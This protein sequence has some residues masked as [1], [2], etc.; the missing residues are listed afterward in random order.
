MVQRKVFEGGDN[1]EE[2]RRKKKKEE[3]EK[4]RNVRALTL[5]QFLEKASK[6]KYDKLTK[7]TARN[8]LNNL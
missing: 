5:S 2:G 8:T 1:I 4:E 6:K 7:K 3:E